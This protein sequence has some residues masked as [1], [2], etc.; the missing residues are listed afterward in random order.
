MVVRSTP[1]QRAALE[2]VAQEFADIRRRFDEADWLREAQWKSTHAVPVVA[3]PDWE[4]LFNAVKAKL[5]QSSEVLAAAGAGAGLNGHA[6]DIHSDLQDSVTALDR[7]HAMLAVEFGRMK[8]IEALDGQLMQRPAMDS[9]AAQRPTVALLV[10][11]LDDFRSIDAHHGRQAGDEVLAII[12]VRLSA[13]VRS[14]DSVRHVGGDALACLLG[15]WSDRDQLLRLVGKL[16]DAASAPVTVGAQEVRVRP[17]IGIAT[18][19]VDGDSADALLR[20]ADAAMAR[21]KRQQTTYA[22]F[23]G[24]TDR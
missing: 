2:R 16:A 13:L 5:R 1:G 10:V 11:D 15:D 17:T 4:H 19:P 9:G 6:A 3:V 23:D 7:L 12:A 8:G 21:A 14:Q 24:R 18:G 22:F 20:C